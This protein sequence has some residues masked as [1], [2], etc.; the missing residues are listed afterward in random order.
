M[1]GSFSVKLGAL[2]LTRPLRQN[3]LVVAMG[4]DRT[5]ESCTAAPLY[6]RRGG[7]LP[8]Y[9]NWFGLKPGLKPRPCTQH[10]WHASARACS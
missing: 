4:A 5:S 10:K 7:G 3:S 1:S 2:T 9:A 6:I 8:G